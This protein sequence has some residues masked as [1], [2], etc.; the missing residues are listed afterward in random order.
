MFEN[1]VPVVLIHKLQCVEGPVMWRVL[2]E[3]EEMRGDAILREPITTMMVEADKAGEAAERTKGRRP[4]CLVCCRQTS[5][6][7]GSKMCRRNNKRVCAE[8]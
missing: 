7:T 3:G 5:R 1:S 6:Q 4:D 2:V 8:R